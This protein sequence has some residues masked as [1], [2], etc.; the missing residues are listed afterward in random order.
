[1]HHYIREN[2]SKAGFNT[3]DGSLLILPYGAEQVS[4]ILSALGGAQVDTIL[5]I[6]ILCTVPS[7]EDTINIVVRDLL[8]PGGQF[9]YFEHVLS[10]L[11]D[12][13]WWQRFWAPI[14]QIPTDGCRMDRPTHIWIEKMGV[15]ET[16]GVWKEGR[17]WGKE[18]EPEEN[19]LWHRVGRYVKR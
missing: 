17:V 7:P 5:S 16:V 13:A 18:N 11:P 12:V 4:S 10:H 9:L 3:S 15:G 6:H 19:L 2:A 1:M 14:W 8:R